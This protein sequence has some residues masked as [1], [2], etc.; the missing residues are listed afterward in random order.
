MSYVDDVVV[1]GGGETFEE[2][3]RIVREKLKLK[4]TE[5]NFVFC[6]KTV[7]RDDEGSFYVSQEE[8]AQNIEKIDIDKKRKRD[9]SAS[10]TETELSE[11]RRVIGSVGW[12][13][14]QTR[15]DLLCGVSLL[16]QSTSR[17]TVEE[18]V[19]ANKLVD[20]CREDSKAKL[21]FSSNDSLK[22]ENCDIVVR[23][24]AAFANADDEKLGKKTKSQCGYHIGLSPRGAVDGEDPFIMN[25]LEVFSGTIKRVCRST[26][27]AEV[28]GVLEAVE[29]AIWI[30]AVIA[31]MVDNRFSV[32]GADA[33]NDSDRKTIRV[34]TDAKSLKDTVDRDGTGIPS[35]R[36][37]RILL[38]QLKQSIE[39]DK[40]T[41]DWVDT[42]AMLADSLT[43][44]GTERGFLLNVLQ[45]GTY[46]P[47]Q[48]ELMAARKAEIREGRH[49]R[50][51]LRRANSS[52]QSPKLPRG[53]S[54]GVERPNLME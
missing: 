34:L 51:A 5:N 46:S 17:P 44:I 38:A 32:R 28:N 23:C 9:N 3:F 26:L 42:L 41:V 49:R 15:G 19:E 4:I 7:S 35:D 6:A 33:L 8:A 30:R 31:E 40:V 27:A 43:K 11:L 13:A 22:L 39:Y 37:L 29:A 54:A 16:A 24:D 53:P 14:R 10:L 50:A 1:T 47:R 48:T 18:L 12:V 20:A 2:A 21:K 36:R 45:G 52:A 25:T